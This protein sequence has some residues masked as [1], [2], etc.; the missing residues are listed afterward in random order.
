LT[1][2]TVVPGATVA[3]DGSKAKF[4]MLTVMVS[5]CAP[6]VGAKSARAT[7]ES[8]ANRI[9]VFLMGSYSLA[10]FPLAASHSPESPYTRNRSRRITQIDYFWGYSLNVVEGQFC[11]THLQNPV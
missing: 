8:A 5:P 10:P 2:V 11:E 7:S 1:H 9:I 6:A 4:L 3:L